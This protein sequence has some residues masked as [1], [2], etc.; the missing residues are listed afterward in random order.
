MFWMLV[1]MDPGVGVGALPGVG[2]GL[3]RLGGIPI[4]KANGSNAGCANGCANGD[5]SCWTD[6]VSSI[7]GRGGGRGCTDGAT[8]T[9]LA[10]TVATPA[11][12][13]A[14]AEILIRAPPR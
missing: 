5:A 7:A 14:R 11:I 3:P 1:P 4:R 10:V 2:K 13:A 12:S 6:A 9:A 8:K